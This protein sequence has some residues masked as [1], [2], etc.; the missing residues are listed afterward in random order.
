MTTNYESNIF[1]FFYK[2]T[3]A[4]RDINFVWRRFFNHS[5]HMHSQTRNNL[6]WIMFRRGSNPRHVALSGLGVVINTFQLIVQINPDLI[7]IIF[8][9]ISSLSDAMEEI[10]TTATT[11]WADIGL[12]YMEENEED[13][14]KKADF[15][16]DVPTHYPDV[17]RPNMGCRVLA[18]SNIGKIVPA[19]CRGIYMSL[20]PIFN[21]PSS[22]NV[23]QLQL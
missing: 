2:T 7:P 15:L 22:F 17:K 8:L 21:L 4:L 3:S 6:L 12:Q 14:K 19:I 5:S 16:K 9:L 18:Q 23:S 1:Y 11:L 10:R 20:H 13:L